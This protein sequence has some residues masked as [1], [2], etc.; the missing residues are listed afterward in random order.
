MLSSMGYLE[1]QNFD[2]TFGS[3]T[4]RAIK[5]FQKANEM[6]E[7][8]AFTDDLAKKLYAV[9]GKDE[10]PG[11]ICSCVRSSPACSTRPSASA[12]PTS[13]SAPTSLW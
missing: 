7:T 3:L 13:R 11:A 2:G 6:P 5:A 8:G 12:I 10:P 1:P 9:A 4:A